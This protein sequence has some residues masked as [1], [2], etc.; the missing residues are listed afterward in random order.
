MALTVGDHSNSV[1]VLSC[2]DGK[3]YSRM[4]HV[5]KMHRVGVASYK[6][7]ALAVSE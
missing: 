2:G 3:K 4:R 7:G 5:M 1:T 6:F